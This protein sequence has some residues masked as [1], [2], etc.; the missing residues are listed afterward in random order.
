MLK[1]KKQKQ[2]NTTYQRT[3][4]SSTL[5][6]ETLPIFFPSLLMTTICLFSCLAE[7]HKKLGTT[8]SLPSSLSK[9][10]VF[11]FLQDREVKR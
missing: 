6:T 1:K 8:L 5:E 4:K 11:A 3:T 2:N 10:Y 9:W 7:L